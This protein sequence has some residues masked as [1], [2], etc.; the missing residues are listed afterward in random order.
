MT[1]PATLDR[2]GIAERIPHSGGMCLL[3]RLLSWDAHQVRCSATSHSDAANPLRDAG[4]LAACCAIEYAAQAMALH[5]ALN[6][7]AAPAPGA[8]RPGFLASARQ[9]RL[10]VER[11]DDVAGPIEVQAVIVAGDD[12]QALYRFALHD[13][14][15]RP[16]AEGRAAVVLNRAL[17]T[18]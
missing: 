2:A 14:L 16:L 7:A 4:G 15:G 12:Q 13:A 3:E 10:H 11:L 1:A 9:V 5:A 8:V 6:A 18:P 17:P